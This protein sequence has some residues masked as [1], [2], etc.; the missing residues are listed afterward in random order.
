[1][2]SSRHLRPRRIY[3]LQSFGDKVPSNPLGIPVGFRMLVWMLIGIRLVY[4]PQRAGDDL[5]GLGV[6]DFLP[7]AGRVGMEP[8]ELNACSVFDCFGVSVRSC[9]ED[10]EVEPEECLGWV[11]EGLPL[12]SDQFVEIGGRV[13]FFELERHRGSIETF[14]RREGL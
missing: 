4:L 12:A 2:G 7:V 8:F 1:M 9:A 10:R 11:L 3:L 6:C 14:R 13:Y 5:S